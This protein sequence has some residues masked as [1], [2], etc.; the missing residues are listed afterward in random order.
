MRHLANTTLG[1]VARLSELTEGAAGSAASRPAPVSDQSGAPL[2]LPFGACSSR[3]RLAETHDDAHESDPLLGGPQRSNVV[4]FRFSN[5]VPVTNPVPV[6]QSGGAVPVTQQQILEPD[7]RAIPYVEEG[8]GPIAL[9]LISNLVLGSD[10]LGAVSHY[11]ADE[12][13]F[14]VVRIGPR[15]GSAPSEAS[16][17]ER[18]DD[19]LAVIDHLGL[20]HTWIGGYATGGTVARV[21]AA[22][23]AERVNGLVLLRVEQKQVEL[24]PV[25]PVLIVQ[26]AEDVL[27][28]PTNGDELRTAAPERT[29]VTTIDGADHLFPMSHPIETAMVIEEYLDW[30]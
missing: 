22:Q 3:S 25:I 10:G 24:P 19:S 26:G 7:G 20:A 6:D 17:Q 15:D 13:D 9:V 2:T 12:A 1:G 14:H 4:E 27:T 23:H 8:S 18:A 29:S 28:P 30:D 21:F 16:A 11:L 5:S